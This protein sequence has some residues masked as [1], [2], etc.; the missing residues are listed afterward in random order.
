M[1][2]YQ[3]YLALQYVG[4]V[5]GRSVGSGGKKIESMYPL[6]TLAGHMTVVLRNAQIAAGQYQAQKVGCERGKDSM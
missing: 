6:W 1:I 4:K 3:T 2:P 5:I